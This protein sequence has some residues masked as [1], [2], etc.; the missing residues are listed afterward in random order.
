MSGVCLWV[1]FSGIVW[2]GGSGGL[3]GFWL[4][5]CFWF[6]CIQWVLEVCGGLVAGLI[7]GWLSWSGG[8]VF[9]Y[10]LVFDEVSLL[11]CYVWGR[12]GLGWGCCVFESWVWGF[13]CGWWVGS[14]WISLR[15]FMCSVACGLVV[16][17]LF[18]DSGFG[19]VMVVSWLE[20]FGVVLY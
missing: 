12:F 9:C 8:F 5:G 10:C 13:W 20:G 1:V 11:L 4:G 3:F 2:C 16:S 6:Y 7:C 18:V 17:G 19:C 15:V 14:V